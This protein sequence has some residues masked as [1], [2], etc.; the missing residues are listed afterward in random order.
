MNLQLE[1]FKIFLEALTD[2]YFADVAEVSGCPEPKDKNICPSEIFECDGCNE[3]FETESNL[4]EHEETC[5][6]FWWGLKH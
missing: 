6:S 4:N 5:F 1:N 3:I 2:G